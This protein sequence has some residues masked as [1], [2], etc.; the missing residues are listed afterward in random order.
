MRAIVGLALT[1]CIVGGCGGGG[2]N[3]LA[4]VGGQVFKAAKGADADV[5]MIQTPDLSGVKSAEELQLGEVTTDVPPICTEQVL[6]KVRTAI[7]T[8]LSGPDTRKVFPGGSPALRMNVQC[9]FFKEKGVIGGEGRLDWLVT[10]VDAES[11]V[12]CAVLF[13]EGVSESPIQHGI[14]D[15]STEN[16]QALVKAMERI[17]RGKPL[18]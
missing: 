1:A 12:A 8:Y 6:A 16:T 2:P 17:R 3:P 10:L 15:M 11:G 7:M 4:L 5:T 18:K 14:G 13:V 9:R